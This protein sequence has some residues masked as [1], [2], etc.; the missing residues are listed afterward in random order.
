MNTAKSDE[1]HRVRIEGGREV[2][3]DRRA[4]KVVL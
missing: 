4:E 1:Q 2:E 3:K